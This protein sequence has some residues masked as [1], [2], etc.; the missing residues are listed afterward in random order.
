MCCSRGCLSRSLM[1]ENIRPCCVVFCVSVRGPA[2]I[3]RQSRAGDRSRR[4][5]GEKYRE[6]AEFI[7]GCKALVGLLRQQDFADHLLAGNSMG[8]GLAIDLRLDQRSINVAW[9]DRVT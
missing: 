3:D 9:A 1:L 8:L 7:D 6:R 5:A 2:A 4:V